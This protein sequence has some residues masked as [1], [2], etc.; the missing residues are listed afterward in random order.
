[1]GALAVEAIGLSKTYG[2][3]AALREGHFQLRPGEVHILLGSNG[4]GKST[5]CKLIAGSIRPSGGELSLFGT[6]TSLTGPNDARARGIGV[7]YQE[8]SLSPHLSVAE[9]ILLGAEPLTRWGTVDRAALRQRARELIALFGAAA[10]P[11]LT[12][13]APVS[14]LS[15]DQKQI[16]EVLKVFSSNPR[17]IILDEATSSLDRTQVT[18][19]FERLRVLKAQGVAI[20]L[21]TH[22]MEE[23]F[24]I[25][26]RVTIVRD[27]VSVATLDIAA[28]DKNE[29][30]HHMV[31]A[32]IEGSIQRRVRPTPGL[33]SAL[34]LDGLQGP[35]L[36]P[37]SVSVRRGEILGLG[38]LH[39]QGQSELLLTLF[40]AQVPLA[41]RVTIAGKS[42][43]PTSPRAALKAGIA[44]ISGDRR[45]VG[46]FAGRPVFEN[47]TLSSLLKTGTRWVRPGPL[48]SL[49]EPILT[50][51]KLK[52]PSLAAPIQ[53]LS[54]GNQQKAVIG[55]WLAT[56]P[57][58][59]LLDDPTKGIDIQSKNDLYAM[60]D[61][62]CAEGVGIILYSSE[63]SELLGNA[64]R[65]LV[66]N[67]GRVTEELSGARL[68]EFDLYQAA[69]KAA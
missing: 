2:A 68:T 9:N 60:L 16:V 39:G 47:L 48:R 37:L 27:G 42:F 53:S 29:I 63:D 43:K 26:D 38:G 20:I 17:V 18:I 33:E 59:L 6:P 25:G 49:L 1:M 35:G 51:L 14:R 61:S 24:E 45:R 62:L 34:T 8:L 41:G 4:S 44:Y 15:F 50:R 66:F 12:P 19:L 28:T 52:A 65:V 10:G 21:I 3:V 54:G 7:F 5:L 67:S 36:A 55:R 40:G 23:I 56:K 30:V 11:G 31:G 22:R 69:L 13:D 46:V 64:D 58:V 57:K 32:R